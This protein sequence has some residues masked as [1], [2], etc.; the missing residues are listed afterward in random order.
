MQ[1]VQKTKLYEG[2]LAQIE[3]LIENGEWKVGEKI[4]SERE[5]KQKLGVSSAI[6]RETF[7]VLESR[8]LVVSKQGG[9]R[10]LRSVRPEFSDQAHLVQLLNRS[11][12]LDILEVRRA[13]ETTALEL[14]IKRA[15]D[16]EID[17]L[18]H[19]SNANNDNDLQ[20][21]QSY[22]ELEKDFDVCLGKASGNVLLE[23]LIASI[24]SSIRS[25][26]QR[27]IIGF[28]EWL[29]LH[30]QHEEIIKGIRSRNFEEAKKALDD[31][32]DG[33]KKA[34]LKMESMNEKK[35]TPQ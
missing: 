19:E 18:E 7:R 32:L 29:P 14:V 11:A 33:I 17:W 3:T 13:L 28:E 2:V 1:P 5:L 34:L 25:L 15:T 22:K 16:E 12:L 30:R 21:W 35:Q 20:A 9:G 6:L 8:N 27:Y 23:M 4:P 31:H 26:R 10:Y 24:I